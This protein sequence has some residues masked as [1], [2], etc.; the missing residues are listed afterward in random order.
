M[1]GREKRKRVRRRCRKRKL[2]KNVKEL[3]CQIV[4]GVS[5]EKKP[6]KEGDWY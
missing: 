6:S 2:D 4:W 5:E 3:D 1:R